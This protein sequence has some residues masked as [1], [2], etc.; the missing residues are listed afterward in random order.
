KR[1]RGVLS[2][3]HAAGNPIPSYF[4][5]E[6][7]DDASDVFPIEFL[8]MSE[9]RKVLAGQDPFKSL[10]ISTCNL[11]HQV[12]YELRRKLIRLRSLY[13]PASSNSDRL[14][15]LMSDSLE[16]FSVVF[17][18]V[19]GLLGGEVPDDKHLAAARICTLL[20]LDH[21]IF[22]QVERFGYEDAPMLEGETEHVFAAYLG[23]IARII[24]SVD[25]LPES[26]T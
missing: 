23:L 6:E 1:V 5:L 8:D 17:R 10:E 3:W 11:R 9:R 16:S 4:T 13:M 2:K 18:H 12:E 22:A 7:I 19:V 14:A 21:S 25:S 15:R 24:D 20:K 26:R